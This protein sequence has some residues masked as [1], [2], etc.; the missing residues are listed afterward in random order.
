MT[1]LYNRLSSRLMGRTHKKDAPP[2]KELTAN[3][4]PRPA[5]EDMPSLKKKK[6][7][8]SSGGQEQQQ[9]EESVIPPQ[10]QV[11]D[12]S[13][14]MD[15]AIDVENAALARTSLSPN[16][17]AEALED[18]QEDEMAAR[19]MIH[20]SDDEDG[21][22]ETFEA[23]TDP[24]LLHQEFGIYELDLQAKD[25]QECSEDR[26]LFLRLKKSC[27]EL[28]VNDDK[29]A[30]ALALSQ[31]KEHSQKM[32]WIDAN[33]LRLTLSRHQTT[34]RRTKYR[35][36]YQKRPNVIARR[37]E[38]KNDPKRIEKK[39]IYNASEETKQRKKENGKLRTRLFKSTMKLIPDLA[40][41]LKTDPQFLEKILATKL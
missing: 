28:G 29:L 27:T 1:E 23:V 39:K 20:S 24:A 30:V 8:K 12:S 25:V 34:K 19:A 38:L 11:I 9:Q 5:F 18:H 32:S 7:K 2:Q 16:T 35:K 3:A 40:E 21:D 10:T 6:T 17:A 13:D 15:I 33:R 14:P 37:A 26:I 41:R 4:S 31:L 22:S 36:E